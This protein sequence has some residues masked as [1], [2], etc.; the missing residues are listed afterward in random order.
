MRFKTLIL[1]LI[2]SLIPWQNLLAWGQ[3]GHRIIGQIAYNHLNKKAKKNVDAILGERGIVYW[4]NWADEIKSDTIYPKSSQWHY[5]DLN[6]GMSDAEVVATLTH[7]PAKGG[8]MWR[9]T[10]DIMRKLHQ[11]PEDF[12]ALRF[13]IHL[14]GDFFCPMYIAHLDDAGGNKVKMKWFGESTNLH[15]IWDSDLINSR[16]Y[17]FSEYADYLESHFENERNE[18]MG[19]TKEEHLIHSYHL[20]NDIYDYMQ[21]GDEDTYHYVYRFAEDM[22]RQ[23]YAAGLY[24]AQLLN[25]IYG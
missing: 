8:E 19:R 10:D 1:I 16:G 6:G 7:Y 3:E 5:Q 15:R 13:F 4:A 17:S 24:L 18:I 20:C 21:K 11:N 22:E 2:F 23:L 25:E 12:D 9:A 14:A